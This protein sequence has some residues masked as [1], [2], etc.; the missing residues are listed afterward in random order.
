MPPRTWPSSAARK[1]TM[2]RARPVISI[3]RPRNTKNGTAS[4]MSR[5]ALVHAADDDGQRRGVTTQI[6]QVPS[7]EGE[8][9][10]HADGDAG[11]DDQHEEHQQIIVAD[12]R[13]MAGEPQH[14]AD[15]EDHRSAI[16]TSRERRVS[17]RRAIATPS[18][19][20]RRRGLPWRGRRRGFR[21]PAW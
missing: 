4:R 2:A 8:G 16:A 6:G 12:R 5:H 10:R 21:A 18:S 7:A 15:G 13:S 1:P 17:A 14:D 3:S 19:A 11:G 9:D 20:R